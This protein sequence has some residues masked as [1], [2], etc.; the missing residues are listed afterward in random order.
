MKHL[1]KK[2]QYDFIKGD[3]GGF[4]Y[5]LHLYLISYSQQNLCTV[6]ANFPI[7]VFHTI[8]IFVIYCGLFKGDNSVILAGQS[9]WER[10]R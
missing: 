1:C 9:L 7:N 5:V 2:N 6:C 3:F 8:K 4:G 10:E